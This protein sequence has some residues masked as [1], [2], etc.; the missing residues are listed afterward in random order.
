MRRGLREGGEGVEKGEWRARLKASETEK[1]REG[2][3]KKE[4]A[5]GIGNV[6]AVINIIVIIIIIIVVI[7]LLQGPLHGV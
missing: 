6:D 7:D 4:E 3:N 5:N 1:G 2:R